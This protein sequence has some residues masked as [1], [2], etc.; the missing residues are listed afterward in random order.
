M[1]VAG[2]LCITEEVAAWFGAAAATWSRYET[3][4][5]VQAD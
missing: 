4:A 5:V 1:L 2:P 3:L